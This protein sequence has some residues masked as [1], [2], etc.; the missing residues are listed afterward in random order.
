MTT[1]GDLINSKCGD[2]TV[3]TG[4]SASTLSKYCS[5]EDCP[6][7]ILEFWLNRYHKI[8]D[9]F[10]NDFCKP[11]TDRADAQL[12]RLHPK[13]HFF[14][15]TVDTRS[16]KHRLAVLSLSDRPDSSKLG[17]RAILSLETVKE[18]VILTI[19]NLKPHMS[20]PN[21]NVWSQRKIDGESFS[22]P[23]AAAFISHV[24]GLKIPND[25]T[26]TGCWN[27]INRTF[28]PMDEDIMAAKCQLAV[29][30]GFKRMLVPQG[31]KSLLKKCAY[32]EYIEFIEIENLPS[33]LIKL[34]EISSLP[35]HSIALH[36]LWKIETTPDLIAKK[37]FIKQ[38]TNPLVNEGCDN[39]LLRA[40][41]HYVLAQMHKHK[42]EDSDAKKHF[43]KWE[44]FF[45]K[46]EEELPD[47]LAAYLRLQPLVSAAVFEIDRGVFE[48]QNDCHEKLNECI[49]HLSS[50]INPTTP[51][52]SFLKYTCFN[53]RARRS[54]YLGRKNQD[55]DTIREAWHDATICISNVEQF[56]DLIA[57]QERRDTT[58][59]R[60]LNFLID[61]QASIK[62]IDCDNYVLEEQDHA[63]LEKLDS[64]F[65]N[66]RTIN[67]VLEKEE[68][69]YSLCF[70]LVSWMK[71]QH[72][73]NRKPDENQ[74]S[75]IIDAT[76]NLGPNVQP[77]LKTCVYEYILYRFPGKVNP[78]DVLPLI[79]KSTPEPGMLQILRLRTQFVLSIYG[80]NLECSEPKQNT[81]LYKL[82]KELEKN[83]NNIFECCPY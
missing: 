83:T 48:N 36:A 61:I 65:L 45:N 82:Y 64:K 1:L 23:A 3:F 77:Y 37:E 50:D 31:Q 73:F 9:S 13:N 2:L 33:L 76:K 67:Y 43:G 25:L 78:K 19:Q 16:N 75:E 12:H 40:H 59:Q 24:Y 10:R 46:N 53:T 11:H 54:L 26:A 62:D 8:P 4:L 80:V 56:K 7:W 18:E 51:S 38:I 57:K 66:D 72:L 20:L 81:A 68:D 79:D 55:I 44:L 70:T 27:R 74:F 41:A 6:P 39:F 58:I 63:L 35:N 49:E 15:L 30:W 21:V 34:L 29:E 5:Y 52:N 22:L 42:G 69:E 14:G 17:E 60:V 28:K 47:H 32:S 71:L